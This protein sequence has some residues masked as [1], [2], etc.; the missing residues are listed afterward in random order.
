MQLQ[1]TQEYQWTI[2]PHGPMRV[3]GVV[4]SSPTLL[5]AAQE[6]RSL[7]QVENVAAL[8]G[9]VKASYAMPDIHWGY[10]FPIGGVAATDIDAG[11]VVSP[12]GV[13]FDISCGVR[14]L[15]T[16]SRVEQLPRPVETIMAR[17][18]EKVPAGMG[19]G[20]LWKVDSRGLYDVLARGAAAAVDAGLG[21]QTDLE[22]SED[23]GGVEVLDVEGVSRRA[24]ERG[25]NQLGSL[26]SGNHFLEVQ[27][28]ARVMDSRVAAA[29]GL[30]EG[31]IT[32]MIH[33]GSRGLGHQ[34]CSDA[35]SVMQSAMARYGIEVPDRQL[36]CVPVRSNEGSSYL[37]MMAAAANYGRANRQAITA[38]VREAL[39][40]AGPIEVVYDVS[41]NLA[42]IE[43]H[44]VD[45]Q[46]RKLCVHRKGATRALPPDHPDLPHAY[47]EVGQPVLI[48]GSMGTASYVLVG[49]AG[50]QAFNSTC[51]GAGRAMSRHAALKL[52][53]GKTVRDQL[54]QQGII[55]VAKAIRA[56][57]EEAPEAYKDIDEVVR[58]CAGAGLSSVVARLEPLGVLKG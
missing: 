44:V 42:K 52:K 14:L 21:T 48:P 56:L 16:Q 53:A 50:N 23:G 33:T 27:R 4:F 28:V 20:A 34:I 55:A 45:G 46:T 10:G 18:E 29:F 51:H 6:D 57:G 54:R 2:P 37:N 8:P 26:G 22:H 58:V 17:L 43:E 5:P 12:G 41:H 3:P 39:S 15:R 47:R 7:T 19:R 24:L 25:L 30:A 35:L 11:G 49:K 9:I 40:D 38:A 36:A 13:G 31:M 32:V 1:H